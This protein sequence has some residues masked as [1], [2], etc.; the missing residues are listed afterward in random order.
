MF[1]HLK[2][3]ST[4]GKRHGTLHAAAGKLGAGAGDK[5]RLALL[6]IV[7]KSKGLPEQYN[8]A[9]LVL[10]MSREGILPTVEAELKAAGRSLA[11]ELPHMYVSGHLAK[12]LLK[13][14]PDL[15]HTEADARKLLKEQFPQV[16]DVTSRGAAPR[17]EAS[18][19][20]RSRRWAVMGERAGGVI[21]ASR[22]GAS[23][24]ARKAAGADGMNAGGGVPGRAAHEDHVG[25]STRTRR[26]GSHEHPSDEEVERQHVEHMAAPRGRCSASPPHPSS[27]AGGQ[28]GTRGRGAQRRPGMVKGAPL[29]KAPGCAEQHVVS[30]PQ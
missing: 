5:V 1:E 29:R 30:P 9:Q 8:Q 16:T 2:E 24:T 28:A 12:A 7:F 4:Q 11:Q 10:W 3:L 27:P 19:D 25:P 6:G 22:N 20:C 15:A 13:A 18:F 14:R 17:G 21:L 26:T 23:P